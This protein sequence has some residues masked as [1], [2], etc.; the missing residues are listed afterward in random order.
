MR[1]C[2]RQSLGTQKHVVCVC[3]S[4]SLSVYVCMYTYTDIYIVLIEEFDEC[5]EEW[6]AIRTPLQVTEVSRVSVTEVSHTQHTLGKSG[7]QSAPRSQSIL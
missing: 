5:N 7:T 2:A 1:A 3:V 4:L 6:H